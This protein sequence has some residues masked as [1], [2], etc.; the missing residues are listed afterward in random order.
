M[1][2]IAL[3]LTLAAAMATGYSQQL[4]FNSQYMVNHYLLNPA[5]AGSQDYMPIAT[6]FRQQWAGFNGAPNTQVLSAHGNINGNMGVGG[7]VYNDVTGPLRNVGFQGTYAYQFEVGRDAKLALGLSLML[8]QYYL[9]GSDFVLNDQVDAVLNGASYKSLN[10]DAHFGVYFYGENYF[11]GI[12]APQ[13]IEWKYDFIA[14]GDNVNKQ[15]RH[16]YFQGGYLIET[17]SDVT[18]EPSA[19]IKYTVGAPISFDIN[20]RFF[21]KENLWAGL[22]YRHGES[23]VGMVGVQRDQFVLGYSY[24]YITNNLQNYSKGT[25]EI[26]IEYQLDFGGSGRRFN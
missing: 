23:V 20:T 17:G 4:T 16:Y 12:A 10:P 25:H 15:V 13:L 21:Y 6:S 8:N 18:I 7:M 5:A 22:S 24:D 11:A 2:K 14:D 19:L 26:Y 3:T 1:K 9:D